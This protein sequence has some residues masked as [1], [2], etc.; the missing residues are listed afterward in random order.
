MI[1]QPVTSSPALARA[2]CDRVLDETRCSEEVRSDARLVVSELVTNA[3]LHAGTSIDLNVR[4]EASALRIEV[5][6][7]GAD[8]PQVWANDDMSGRGMRIVAALGQAWGVLDLASGKTVWCEI[9]LNN[10]SGGS[11]V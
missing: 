11:V 10:G 1:L 8:R 9:P 4:L 3:V 7:R 2:F 6:D 5:T